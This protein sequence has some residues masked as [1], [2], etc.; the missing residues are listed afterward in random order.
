M[1]LDST[2]V[3]RVAGYAEVLSRKPDTADKGKALSLYRTAIDLDPKDENLKEV[4]AKS[5]YDLAKAQRKSQRREL[6]TE[7]HSYV[8]E[9]FEIAAQYAPE[10]D[11]YRTAYGDALLKANRPEEAIAE[12]QAVVLRD[13]NS[14]TAQL[15]LSRA[16][17]VAG[18]TNAAEESAQSAHEQNA[19]AGG[20]VSID[21]CA[22]NRF[23]FLGMNLSAKFVT[24]RVGLSFG[25]D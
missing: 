12:I 20:I 3:D 9:F 13:S 8:A 1:K 19:S 23:G 14:S 22:P 16:Q 17:L 25:A 21:A 7:Y 5:A 11:T 2:V 10:N 15:N 18:H 6:N 4:A 24:F